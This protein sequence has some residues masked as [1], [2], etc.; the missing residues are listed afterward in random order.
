MPR[1]IT[2][3][4]DDGSTHIYQNA[5]DDITPDA[6]ASRAQQEFSKNVAS[7][8][9]GRSQPKQ[10]DIAAPEVSIPKASN[11]SN[12]QSYNGPHYG[13]PAETNEGLKQ[14]A[15]GATKGAAQIGTTLLWPY[16]AATDSSS[17]KI[18][19]LI[20]GNKPLTKHQQRVADVDSAISG[21]GG[22]HD[23][24]GFKI[25]QTLS[26]VAGTA[27]VGP[28]IGGAVKSIPYMMPLGEAITSSGFVA[29]KIAGDGVSAALKSG[30]LRVA[31]GGIAGGA[32]AGAINPESAPEGVLIGSFLPSAFKT[33]AA[34]SSGARYLAQPFTESGQN[35]I[36]GSVLN[37]FAADPQ[38]ALTALKSAPEAYPSGALPTAAE[39]SGD[40]GLS[41]L[42]R[43][44]MN[45]ASFSNSMT[46]RLAE[47]NAKRTGMLNEIAGNPG[48]IAAAQNE[49]KAATD[50]LR[51]NALDEAGSINASP[52]LSGLD[53][54]LSNP[55]NAGKISQQ[56][57]SGI[58]SQISDLVDA[59]GKI[60]ARAAYA[61]RK[62]IGDILEGRLQGESGNLKNASSQL[63]KAKALIDDSIEGALGSKS[64]GLTVPPRTGKNIVD[65]AYNGPDK[66]ENPVTN[67]FKKYLKTYSDMSRP[68]DQMDALQSVL[69]RI[70]NN[71]EDAGGNLTLSAAKLTGILKNESSDL[72]KVLT[73]DQMSTL[74]NL[75]AELN[76]T[77]KGI[78]AGK[79][80]GSNTI[81]N[82][83]ID[84]AINSML[85]DTGLS[86]PA[87]TIIG[88][89]ARIAHKT[90]NDDV[91][92]K[93]GE[94]LLDP[95]KAAQL[96][97]MAQ[98]KGMTSEGLAKYLQSG[99][100]LTIS[101]IASQ[102]K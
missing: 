92:Q 101:E 89:V 22:N 31:G 34:A 10:A 58:K 80:V 8:D 39:A 97:E 56:A 46:A 85:G 87:R 76:A 75:S 38:Q 88:N 40:V 35:K 93:L 84:R 21:M 79:P 63:I 86:T 94:A 30:A 33:V 48:K 12:E 32:T 42:T 77:Q 57:L 68:I 50:A 15:L 20:S 98:R 99:T 59:D 1:N 51:E 5:P 14:T 67:S 37:D 2:V 18:S 54:L 64:K 70:Q 36:V 13:S 100:R 16:D 65:L 90:G 28:A 61:I 41:G 82:Y 25:G 23:D 43:G 49:R 27:G 62:D 81:Q 96:M 26:Q 69:K 73:D 102:K 9:G 45:D 71:T 7:L 52:I 29:P 78:N 44:M 55:N 66:T 60:S 53:E 47:Q 3:T 4:F 72:K 11:A 6:V 91:M 19:D 17:S 95:K 74:N 24:P 83:N